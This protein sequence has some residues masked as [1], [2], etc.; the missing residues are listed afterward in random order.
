VND[1]II[2]A[3][4]NIYPHELEE[5]IGNLPGIRKGCIAVFGSIDHATATEKLVILAETHETEPDARERL[6]TAIT[7]LAVDLAGAAPDDVVL[8]PPHTVLKT[9]S[10]KVR[11]AASRELYER[12]HLTAPTRPAWRRICIWPGPA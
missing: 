7:A 3:G 2:R 4:R 12:G 1:I 9:S 11:R 8:A 10:G 5:A 6:Q